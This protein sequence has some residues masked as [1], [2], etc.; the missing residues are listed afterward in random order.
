MKRN[1]YYATEFYSADAQDGLNGRQ[2]VQGTSDG[3]V[4]EQNNGVF[5]KDEEAKV[6]QANIKADSIISEAETRARERL[7]VYEQ[8]GE[9]IIREA[10][11]EA[12]RIRLTAEKE[13][14]YII[15][16]AKLS[17][18]KLMKEA[19]VK[20]REKGVEVM[21]QTVEQMQCKAISEAESTTLNHA[22]EII[23]EAEQRAKRIVE[24]AERRASYL[25]ESEIKSKRIESWRTRFLQIFKI[26]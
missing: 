15:N 22:K 8:R 23:T 6:H 18:H 11:A 24:D 7:A 14:N 2:S 20:A 19:E 25:G 10:E 16:R 4:A 9:G 3:D 26:T 5:D 13:A 1:S 12:E 21:A 17:T